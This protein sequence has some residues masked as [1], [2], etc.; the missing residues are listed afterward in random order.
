MESRQ[1]SIEKCWC[2][3][4]N[5]K[6]KYIVFDDVSYYYKTLCISKL[7]KRFD[8]FD[9]STNIYRPLNKSEIQ[10]LLKIGL[11]KFATK[12]SIKNT[13]KSIADNRVLFHIAIAKKSDKEKEFYYRKTM[14]RIK[15][16][17]QLLG[18]Q[19]KIA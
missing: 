12:L 3:F 5:I 17:R 15:K 2:L 19:Q 18:Y 7:N 4:K 6:T 13:L 9:T 10:D 1:E 11:E 16:L 14:R 8:I